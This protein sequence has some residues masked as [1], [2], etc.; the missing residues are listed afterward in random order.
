M[1]LIRNEPLKKHTSFRVGGPADYFCVP[2]NAEQLRAALH[3]ARERRLPVAVMGAG[4]NLLA[5]DRG[6]RGLVVKL[7]GGLVGMKAKGRYL[8]VG[9]GVPLPKLVH[10]AVGKGLAGLEFL[11]GIPGSVGGAVAMNAGAWQ[12]SIGA[13]ISRVK[14][15]DARGQ[16]KV[17]SKKALHFS[18]R[19]SVLQ[20]RKLIVTEVVLRLRRGKRPVMKKKVQEYLKLRAHRQPLGSPNAGSV[21]KNPPRKFAGQL[22]EAA[23][24]KGW[25]VGDAQVSNK[26]ANFIV[27][28]GEA[29]AA[30]IIKLMT[31]VQKAVKRRLE[32]EIKIMVKSNYGY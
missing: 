20:R 15:L 3:F 11:A 5:L 7:G 23:G 4:T 19:R 10:Y 31:K 18:Y 2:E 1:R 16:E 25:R 28:L 29:K 21:F 12:K 8:Y 27:N 26:H 9:S 22:I 6:F 30:D 24:C 32:P 13:V 14:V 17:L